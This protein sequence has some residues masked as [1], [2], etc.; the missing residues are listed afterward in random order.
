LTE[1]QFSVVVCHGP[2]GK[3]CTVPKL[4]ISLSQ[5][6]AVMCCSWYYCWQPVYSIVL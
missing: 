5:F 2:V 4:P 6:A 1:T 3:R